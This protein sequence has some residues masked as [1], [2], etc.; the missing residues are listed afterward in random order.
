MLNSASLDVRG[1]KY[2]V[3]PAFVKMLLHC[4]GTDGSTTFTDVKGKSVTP[5]GNAQLKVNSARF[6]SAGMY[7][8]GTG[9]FLTITH[10]DFVFGTGDFSLSAWINISSLAVNRTVFATR[11]TASSATN[12]FSCGINTSGQAYMWYTSGQNATGASASVAINGWYHFELNRKYG[13]TRIFVNG[14]QQ[15]ELADANNLDQST[16]YVGAIGSGVEPFLGSM[17]E[18]RV[19]TGM[20][21]NWNAFTPPLYPYEYTGPYNDP[22]YMSRL[23]LVHMSGA[24]AG[25]FFR[26]LKGNALVRNGAPVTT[27]AQ[28]KYGGSSTQ[29]GGS[30]D[31]F[32]LQNSLGGWTGDFSIEA[33]VKL[34][35]LPTGTAYNTSFYILGG[36]SGLNSN[37][38]LDF[39]IGNNAIWFNA[40][41][42]GSREVTA[43]WTPDTTTWHHICVDRFSGTATIYVD[44][45]AIGSGASTGAVA[46]GGQFSIGR[47]EQSGGAAAGYMNGFMQEL[48]ICKQSIYRGQ[49]FTPP[50]TA[51]YADY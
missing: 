13:K 35:A 40:T 12:V 15:L 44:G 39:A 3:S 26:E 14:V 28:S 2:D 16:L 25:T 10:S 7:L 20:A 51:A 1:R 37:P 6:G 18:I 50:S 33:W 46:S 24:N 49:A 31:W 36:G 30:A 45:V 19:V 21:A 34:S 47:A 11:P 4:D 8:D 29:F 22:F 41:N 48:S 23:S 27:T 9:D 38:G 42:Y 17:D 32:D 5:N 43:S